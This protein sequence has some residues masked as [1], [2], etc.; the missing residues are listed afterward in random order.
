MKKNR[1]KIIIISIFLIII[2]A[3]MWMFSQNQEN[4]LTGSEKQWIT[5]NQNTVQNINVVN[6]INL[7]GDS[8]KGVYYNFLNAFMTEYDVKL[9]PVTISKNESTTYLA[10]T[11]GN[12]LPEDAFSFFEDHYV[13]V[14]KNNEFITSRNGLDNLT[15]GILNRD[16]EYIKKY[17][18]DL[19]NTKYKIYESESDLL[20]SIDSNEV[21]SIIIPRMEFID[22]ILSKKY[23]INYHFSDIKRIFYVKENSNS[24]LYQIIKKYY[25]E[26][27]LKALS[28]EIY[29]EERSIFK[30]NLDISDTELDELQKASIEYAYKTYLPYEVYGD[31]KYGGILGKYITEFTDFAKLDINYTKYSNDKKLNRDINNN[32]ITILSN[33]Y[34]YTSNGTIIDTNI[35]LFAGVFT[36]NSIPFVMNSPETLKGQT[37]Y[38]EEKSFLQSKLLNMNCEIK[39]FKLSDLNKIIK[40]KNNIIVIDREV[41]KYLQKTVLKNYELRYSYDL[42]TTYTLKSFGNEILNKLLTRYINYLDNQAM[43]QIGNYQAL[44]IEKKGSLISSIASYLLSA[45]IIVVVILLLIYRSSKK[46]RL[47]KKIKKEDKLKFVDHLTSLKNRNYF[48]ENLATWNKNTIYPQ[49]VIVIDLNRLQEINDTVGYEEGDKQIKASA[50]ILIKTQLDNTD[51]IRTNGNEF[52]VYLVG[53][54]QKQITSYIHKLYKEFSKNLPYEYGAC[55]SYSMINDDLKLI[56]DAVNECVE[57]IKKQKEE[58]KEEEK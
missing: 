43:N 1:K 9:N 22:M 14:G 12:S 19:T 28:S 10:L 54:N 4:K 50:N 51:I 57:D 29:T 13:L 24:T 46:V 42:N 36:H 34:N 56:E 38:V 52:V 27:S 2:I 16:A 37:I 48:N 41:G 33:F 20:K 7:F 3:V 31:G 44:E 39:L 11:V 53:Y 5:N 45:I 58:K 47:Q 18:N 35:P 23:W 32:K 30:E 17:L 21:S 6:N 49:G 25:N 55:I 15:I 8:G 40:D 26:W